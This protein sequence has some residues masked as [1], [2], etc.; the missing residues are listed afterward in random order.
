MTAVDE[1]TAGSGAARPGHR[2]PPAGLASAL[3]PIIGAV[4]VFDALLTLG[5]EVLFL[6]LYLG[7]IAFPIA[8]PIAGIVNVA[9]MYGMR[10]VSQRVSVMLLPLGVWT[11]GFLI[12]STT[13]PGGDIML[14]GDWRTLLLLAC[15]L[16]APLLFIYFRVNSGL[17]DR[18]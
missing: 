7:T 17:F 9:L 12:C 1:P 5:L 18:R 10:A 16:I 8:A 3:G 4:L 15:G 6:P 14:A 2:P 13:G 11:F